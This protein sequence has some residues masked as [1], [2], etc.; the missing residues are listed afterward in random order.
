MRGA[1]GRAAGRPPPAGPRRGRGGGGRSV[2]A[3][4]AGVVSEQESPAAEPQEERSRR[5]PQAGLWQAKADPLRRRL[6]REVPD[7]AG[8]WAGPE[9]PPSAARPTGRKPGILWPAVALLGAAVLK[10]R[11][12]LQELG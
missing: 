6:P 2:P 8:A 1:G 10:V 5:L 9:P 12:A 3:G 7:D 11:Y 4:L